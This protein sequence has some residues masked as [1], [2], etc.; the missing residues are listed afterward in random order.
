MPGEKKLNIV[1]SYGSSIDQAHQ[2]IPVSFRSVRFISRKRCPNSYLHETKN[3]QSVKITN[4]QNE[5]KKLSINFKHIRCDAYRRMAIYLFAHF[6][7]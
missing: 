5:K 2:T 4:Q 3:K 7:C 6:Q 1:I